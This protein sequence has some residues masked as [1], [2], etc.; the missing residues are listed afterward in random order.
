M[1]ILKKRNKKKLFIIGYGF[2]AKSLIDYLNKKK[3]YNIFCISRSSRFKQKENPDIKFIDI[4]RLNKFKLNKAKIVINTLGNINH[5]KFN[6]KSENQI[7]VDHFY[8][9]KIILDN[10]EINAKTLFIQIGSIDEIKQIN[11]NKFFNTPYALFKNY[12]SN[13][14]LTLK[15][16]KILNSKIIYINSVF[17]KYQKNDRLIPISINSLI[18]NQPFFPKNPKQ[19]RNFISS[20]EFAESI[21]KIILNH[22]KFKDRIIIQSIFDY[23]VGDIVS[24]ILKKTQIKKYKAKKNE[25]SNYETFIVDEKLNIENKLK[26]TI[27]S[28][29]N[30]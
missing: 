30:E 21:Y 17:G 1:S 14:L 28:Y 12:F 16:N 11:K 4:T 7:F 15:F 26:K 5:D 6:S 25:N 8:L 18:K 20:D 23:K 27:D 10:I 2:L 3:S 9:P 19:K 29:I 22:K 13:Y 24:F